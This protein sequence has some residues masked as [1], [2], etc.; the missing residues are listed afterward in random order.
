MSDFDGA[1]RDNYF[2]EPVSKAEVEVRLQVKMMWRGDD[3][4]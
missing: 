1:R 2:E 4:E 3:K